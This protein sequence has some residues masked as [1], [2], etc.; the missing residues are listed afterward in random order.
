MLTSDDDF[1]YI[2]VTS[3]FHKKLGRR[4]H[5]HECG[6]KAFRLRIRRK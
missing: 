3:F 2:Y 5:A 1:E 6:K 4:I